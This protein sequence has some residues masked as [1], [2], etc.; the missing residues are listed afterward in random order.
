[1]WMWTPLCHS[2]PMYTC[3]YTCTVLYPILAPGSVAFL[4]LRLFYTVISVSSFVARRFVFNSL[5][6]FCMLYDPKFVRISP[7]L[8]Q[9]I[10]LLPDYQNLCISTKITPYCACLLG[11]MIIKNYLFSLLIW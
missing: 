4:R 7:C 3:I 10:A 5:L 1:M 2:C 11:L 8:A 9:K 6:V